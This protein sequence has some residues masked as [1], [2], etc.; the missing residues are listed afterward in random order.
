MLR[1]KTGAFYPIINFVGIHVVPTLVVWGCVL[2][3]AYAFIFDVAPTRASALFILLSVFAAI[4]QGVADG[5]CI[6]SARTE[7]VLLYETDFGS[8]R[9]TRT[10]SVR[11][12][13]G[14]K[15]HF[16]FCAQI[17]ARLS[18]ALEPSQTLC[19]F[20]LSAFLSRIA[21][22]RQNLNLISINP[23]QECFFL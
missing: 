18:F 22:N 8:T 15:L 16:R 4:L 9:A 7:A 5:K 17:R 23:K 11:Y 3:A 12:L 20:S 2:P 21:G 14:G 13:C 19:C 1:E 10:I 6:N